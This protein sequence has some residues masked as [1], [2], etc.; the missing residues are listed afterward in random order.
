MRSLK[1]DL[2]ERRLWPLAIVIVAAIVAVP[3]VLHSHPAGGDVAPPPATK[4]GPSSSTSPHHVHATRRRATPQSHRR[5][6]FAEAAVLNAAGKDS[7][8]STAA[9]ATASTSAPTAPPSTSSA[10]SAPS[11]APSSGNTVSSASSSGGDTSSS[12]SQSSATTT[13]PAT[14][15]PATTPAPTTTPATTTPGTTPV[16]GSTPTKRWNI[17][18]VD[19]RIGAPGAGVV[20]KDIP[21]LSPLPTE[22]SPQVM[23]M[24]VAD[25]GRRAVFALGA[26][27]EAG[28]VGAVRSAGAFCDPSRADCALLVIPAG[29]SVGLSYVSSTGTV[30]TLVLDV[31]RIASQVTGST[32]ALNASRRHIS[33]VGLCDLKLGDPIGF[34]NSADGIVNIPSTS[35][36]RRHKLAVP[37]PGSLGA[38]S[39]ERG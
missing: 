4:G 17:Y 13:P 7:A 16:D 10:N 23:Y 25:N 39:S 3:F 22:R 14:T 9:K 20:H 27:V 32:S 12:P 24:G 19:V 31:S 1:R 18:S 38:G 35:T 2:F 34:F 29:K 21:R 26:G 37:F 30:R 36:C 8:S 33:A 11:S 28:A 15:T 6:P 5:D